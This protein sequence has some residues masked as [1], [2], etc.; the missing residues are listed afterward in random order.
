MISKKKK[1]VVIDSNSVVYRAFHALPPLTTKNGDLINAVY[2]FLLVFLKALNYFQPDYIVA[3][4]DLPGPTFRHQ[5]FKDYKIK[6]P[7]VPAGI[8][9]QLPKVKEVLSF[10]NVPIFEKQGFEADDVIATIVHQASEKIKDVEII[11]LSGDSDSFCL[12]NHQTKVY[13]LKKGVKE[14]ILYDENKI[15][16][17][18]QLSP[19]QLIDFKAL[20]G[21]PSDNVPGV[22]GIGEKTALKLIKDFGSL[23]DLYSA[24]E[25]KEKMQLNEKLLEKLK[26]N[27]EQVFFSKSLIQLEKNVPV[28]FILKNYFW[29]EF[30]Q[31]KAIEI[32]KKYEFN[33][34]IEKITGIMSKA[35][36]KTEIKTK[37]LF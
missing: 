12:I 19:Q 30:D 24:I 11:I 25:K 9:E 26:K 5:K 17:R 27:K 6:R 7:P 10:F 20:K 18:Y 23:E 13:F 4:F 1:L 34:L 32:L 14:I 37:T 3:T 35:E 31:E 2:G 21:D 29:Q 36:T 8:K 28:D 15:K 16:E 33:S 22:A